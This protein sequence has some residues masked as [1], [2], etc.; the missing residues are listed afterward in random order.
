LVDLEWAATAA[1][2]KSHRKL[3]TLF[4]VALCAS[5]NELDLF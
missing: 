3:Y 4:I 1:V 5:S 2:R